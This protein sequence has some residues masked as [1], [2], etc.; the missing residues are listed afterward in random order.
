ME[1]VLWYRLVGGLLI[2]SSIAALPLFGPNRLWIGMGVMVAITAVNFAMLHNLSLDQRPTAVMALVDTAVLLGV[3]ALVPSSLPVAAVVFASTTAL[4]VF[5]FGSR[6]TLGLTVAVVAGFSAV[7][8]AAD[9]PLWFPATVALAV[10]CIVCTLILQTV[11][12]GVEDTQRRFDELVNGIDAVVWEAGTTGRVDF[13]SAN[14]ADVLGCDATAFADPAFIDTHAHPHD[15][16]SWHHARERNSEGRGSEVHLRVRDDHHSYRRIQ[17][18]VKVSLNPDGT[19]HRHRGLIMDETRRWDAETD[20]RRYSDFIQGI[21]IALLIV[22]LTDADD[23]R[24][25]VVTSLNPA[26][27]ALLDAANAHRNERHTL[28]DGPVRLVDCLDIEERWLERLRGVTMTN[29]AYERPF[30]RI[31]GAE[32][33]YAMRAVPLPD[34]CIGISLEDVTRRERL[35]ESFRHQALH[36]Q[37]TGLP[38]RAHLHTRLDAAL[39]ESEQTGSGVALLVVDLDQF[40]EVNDALGHEYGDRLLA[41]LSRRLGAKL[42]HCDTIARLGGDE[43]AVLLTDDADVPKAT[44]V[45]RRLIALCEKPIKIGEFRFQ[46]SASVGVA[47]APAH[48]NDTDTLLRRADGAMYR[49][50]ASGGSVSVYSPGQDLYNVRRL[51]LLGDLRDA[52][53]TDD[54]AVQ[55]QPR[56]DLRTNRTVGVEALVRWHHPRHGMLPPDEFIELAEVSGTIHRLTQHVSERASAEM[57]PLVDQHDLSLSVNL[58]TRNLYDAKLVEWVSDLLVRHR[59][60]PGTLCFEI[61]ESQLM[62]DPSHSL[63]V[64]HELRELGIRFSIDDFGTGYSSLSYLRELPIDEVKI[65]RIFVADV[66]NDDTIVRSVIDLGHNLGLHVVAEG[67]EDVVTLG[68]LQELGCDSAQGFHFGA[69][70][71]ADELTTYLDGAWENIIT[72]R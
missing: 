9:P 41:E 55:Y 17:E 15:I 32:G 71:D 57:R 36:D 50:K 56:I 70:M 51:E 62:D 69:P 39:A 61:T 58:S 24:S 52:V 66:A 46:V 4:F 53:G 65:D 49:A 10:C 38:N 44:E 11:A 7:G 33:I 40:K 68:R 20:L 22:Q 47:V 37:L 23:P 19:V 13:V 45:A 18:R 30:L 72:L 34:Q 6:L 16:A 48:G 42:R 2:G 54:L 63:T 14:V 25:V 28:D 5:W 26:A 8:I 27:Q 3:V 29:K 31:P 1:R 43:F 12:E 21:P 67:V 60:A 35:A 64:L 59:I